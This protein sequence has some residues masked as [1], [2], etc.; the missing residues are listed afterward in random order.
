MT[1]SGPKAPGALPPG[2]GERGVAS[3]VWAGPGLPAW[4]VAGFAPPVS[5]LSFTPAL[6][7]PPLLGLP[8]G[9]TPT[10][11]FFGVQ[12][13]ALPYPAPG[14]CGSPAPTP[15][16]SCQVALASPSPPIR[17]P[18]FLACPHGFPSRSHEPGPPPS[19]RNFPYCPDFV[20]E[21]QRLT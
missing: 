5:C 6:S 20:T 1:L 12:R 9:P 3:G 21:R 14:S 2:G 19:L 18:Q 10:P 7:A 13:L 11:A 17:P 15:F 4:G 8:H 16:Q